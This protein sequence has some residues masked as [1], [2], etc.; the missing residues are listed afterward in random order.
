MECFY[1]HAGSYSPGKTI[2]TIKKDGKVI[3]IK[4]VPGD[5]CNACDDA[6]FSEATTDRVHDLVESVKDKPEELQL[7]HYV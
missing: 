7:I 4:D 2:L 5:V 6:L 3:V 1:C